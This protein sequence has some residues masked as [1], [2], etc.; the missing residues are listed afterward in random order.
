MM[1]QRFKVNRKVFFTTLIGLV[2]LF[3]VS[4]FAADSLLKQKQADIAQGGNQESWM[5]EAFSSNAVAGLQA[6]TGPIP[7]DVL[8]GKV[9]GWVPGGMLGVTGNFI[10]SVLNPPVSGISYIA[11]TYHSFLGQPTYAQSD[12]GFQGLQPILPIWRGFRNVVYALSSLVFII[13]GIMIM[14]RVKISPQAVITIQNAIPQLITTIIFVTFSYAIAGLMIDLMNFAQGA[15]LATFFTATG[16]DL[17]TQNFLTGTSSTYSALNTLSFGTTWDLVV[18]NLPMAQ[19]F[20]VSSLLGA[21]I[22]GVSGSLTGPV[23]T[24]IGIGVGLIG[25]IV[26]FLIIVIIIAIS[27]LKFLIALIK[28][29]INV[30][31]KIILAPFEIGIGAFPGSKQGFSSWFLELTANL[32]VFPASVFFLVIVNYIAEVAKVG[33]LWVPGMIA[34]N[35]SLVSFFVAFGGLLLLPKIPELVP[36]A[37]FNVKPS[38]LSQTY[39]KS[40]A[41]YGATASK[42][43]WGVGQYKASQQAKYNA[44]TQADPAASARDKDRAGTFHAI[45]EGISSF[46][47]GRIKV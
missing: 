17:A 1:L 31:I 43:G 18:K 45:W 3:T 46:S 24:G 26:F 12:S 44:K 9:T 19:T 10:A 4:V 22:G 29:Y 33:N 35:S 25:G 8:D 16:K 5:S 34:G 14:L 20:V 6:M 32:A 40:L 41:E 23:G 47:G 2:F 39:D 38:A 7:N 42:A 27:V 13:L 37:L 30:I 36:Q 21:L 28:V 15:I 11:D